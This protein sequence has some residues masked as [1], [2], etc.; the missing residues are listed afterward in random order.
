MPNPADMALNRAAAGERLSDEDCLALLSLPADRLDDLCQ[1]ASSLRDRLHPG[2]LT[3]SPKVFLPVTNLC[4]DRCTYCT[5]R[6]DPGD[7]GQWTMTPTEITD[8]SS[9]GK[10]RGCIEA[11]MCLGDKPEIAFRGFKSVL[12]AYG[13]SSTAD[14]VR[15]ACEVALEQGLLP[16]TNAGLLSRDEMAMLRPVNISMGLMLENVSPRL[17][18]RDMPHQYAPDKDPERR[19]QMIR[20]AGELSIPFTTGILCGIGENERERVE[21]LLA[22][23]EIHERYGHIQEVIVQNFRAKDKT[24][25]FGAPELTDDEMVRIVALAR[26]LLGP[27]V[28]LQAPPNLSPAAHGRLIRAGI[29]DWGGISPLTL[30]YVNPEAPWPHIDVLRETCLEQGFELRARLPIYPEYMD[31]RW[32]DPRMF[33]SLAAFSGTA[34]SPIESG[35]VAV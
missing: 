29:N 6:R 21:S 26:L 8:W 3:Y 31:E 19:L 33:E 20:E 9:K 23:R 2:V 24:P 17:R 32:V 18:A 12:D 16:H 25:M 35:A 22:I 10:A 34:L 27:Q 28:N 14:Y 5:F 13:A 11:L 7:P 1:V 30:D 15:I 4:R